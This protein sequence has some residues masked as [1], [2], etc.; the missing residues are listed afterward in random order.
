MQKVLQ[1]VPILIVFIVSLGVTLLAWQHEKAMAKRDL[2]TEL[3]FQLRQTS[4][5]IVQRMAAYEQMLRGVQGLVQAT[6]DIDRGVFSRYVDALELGA[7]DTGIQGI[8]IARLITA[9]QA[10]RLALDMRRSGLPDFRIWPAGER[11]TYAPLVQVEPPFGRNPLA[12]GFDPLSD[13]VRRAALEQARDSGRP[14]LSGKVRLVFDDDADD[15]PGFLMILPLYRPGQSHDTGPARRTALMGWIVAIF[16][17]SDLIAGLYGEGADGL[18]TEIFDGVTPNERNHLFLGD[19]SDQHLY[20]GHYSADEI[21]TVAGHSWLV[22]LH[23]TPAFE[24]HFGK[25]AAD[26]ILLSGGGIGFLLTLVI[27]QMATSRARAQRIAEKM[28]RDL[29]ESEACWKFALEGA[30]D[31]VWDWYIQTGQLKFSDNWAGV[32]TAAGD[33]AMSGPDLWVSHMHPDDLVAERAR[34]E[35]CLAGRTAVYISEHRVRW[36]DGSWRWVAVRGMIVARDAQGTP[37]RMIGTMSD[38]SERREAEERIRYLAQHDPLTRLP[39]RALFSDRLQ[40]AL[41]RARRTGEHV[42]LMFVDLDRFKPINDNFGHDIG[43]LLLKEVA[44]RMRRCIRDSDTV[45]RIGGDEF[46]VLLP[47]TGSVADA[48]VVAEKIRAALAQ[49][50]HLD[51]CRTSISSSIG[52]ALFPEDGQDALALSKNADDAMYRAKQKGR[53]RVQFYR[54]GRDGPDP[55]DAIPTG[56]VPTEPGLRN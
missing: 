21:V 22:R 45:A 39:N 17:M 36:R 48:L 50:F 8:A 53:N 35:D 38:V 4:S 9:D 20:A 33:S 27:W 23:A 46:V 2:R 11:P 15:Q 32:L 13:P 55:G 14:V 24:S 7:D 28:T 40:T 37:L 30:G 19:G 41:T 34:F 47:A 6:G 1:S 42:A 12:L 26:L 18:V 56:D 51:G 52:V 25:G 29:K 44:D 31:G 49:D 5:R 54:D 10:D 43:D 16:R 3:D